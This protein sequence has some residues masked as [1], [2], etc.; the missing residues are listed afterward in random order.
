MKIRFWNYI[1]A[2]ESISVYELKTSPPF[3]EILDRFTIIDENTGNLLDPP[4]YLD[5]PYEFQSIDNEYGSCINFNT[6]KQLPKDALKMISYEETVSKYGDKLILVAS[7]E[8]R[9]KALAPHLPIMYLNQLTPVHFCLLE[10]IGKSRH[11]GQMTVGK[12]NLS[13]VVKDAKLLFYNRT[14]LQKFDLIKVQ[15]STQVVGGRALKSILLRLN[16]FYQPTLCTQPKI[17]KLH[18]IINYLLEAPDYSEQTDVMIKKGL[19]TPPQSKRLQ[20]TINIFNFEEKDII[21][22][23]GENSKMEPSRHTVK[24]KCISLNCQS[25]ESQSDE[26]SNENDSNLKCQ[27]KVGVNLGRQ[28]YECFL[29]AGLKGLTQIDIAQLLGIEF[30][31][32]RTICRVFKARKIVRE[33]LED[34]GRQRTARYIAIAATK[35]IDK[36][37]AKEKSKFLEHCNKRSKDK[38]KSKGDLSSDSESEVPLKKIKKAKENTPVNET[39]QDITE[40]KIMEGCEN[41]TESLLNQKKNPTLR[42]LKFANGIIKVVQDRKYVMGF[43]VLSN[44]VAKETGEPPMDTKALKI[45]TQKLVADGQ[46]KILKIKRPSVNGLT[47]NIFIC[48]PHIKASNPIIRAKYKEICARSEISKKAKLH[49]STPRNIRP[50]THFTYPRYMKIQKLHEFLTQLVYF[51]ESSCKDSING[52]SSLMSI[53]PEM[54]VELALGHISHMDETDINYIKTAAFSL[55]DKVKDAPIRLNRIILQSRSLINSLKVVLKVLALLGLIQLVHQTTVPINRDATDV[56][57]VNRHAKIINT[58]GKWPQPNIDKTVLEKSYHFKKFEDVQEYWSDVHDISINTTINVPRRQQYKL[59]IPVRNEQNLTNY[60]TGEIFGD[61]LGPCG[62]D[63][64]IY[65]D[66]ARLWRS[67]MIKNHTKKKLRKP[68]VKKVKK[69]SSAPAESKTKIKSIKNENNAIKIKDF[70]NIRKR[71]LDSHIKWSNFEDRILMMCKAAVTI[72]SP[73]S[74]PGCLRVRNIVAKDLLSIFDPRKTAAIC[75]KRAIIL[76]TNSTLAHEKDCILNELRCH[77]NLIQK[78]EGLLRVLRLRNYANLSKYVNESRLPLLQLIWI[79]AQIA[80]TK[81]FNRRMPCMAIDLKDFNKKYNISPSSANRAYNLYRTPTSSRPE[82]AILKEAIIMTIMLSLDEPV[83]KKMGKKIFSIFNVYDEP[84]LRSAIQQL[85]KSGA[86]AARD[87]M[88]NSQLKKEHCED[89]VQTMYKIAMMYRR[90]WMSHLEPEFLDSLSELLSSKIPHNGLKGSC[91]INCL[92]CETYSHDVIDIVSDTIPVVTGSAGSILQEEQ[93]NVID[94]ETKF[95]LKS[96]LLGWKNK[97]NVETF[98]ELY[99]NI[100]YDGIFENLIRKSIVDYSKTEEIDEMDNIIQFLEEKES[101]GCTFKELDEKIPDDQNTLVKRLLDLESKE[102]VKRVGLYENVIVL[103]KYAKPY[104]LFVPKNL[105]MIPTPWLTLKAEIQK[106]VFF[107][108]AGVIMNKVFEC[109]GCSVAFISNSIE[110]IT[111]R[112]VQE[113]CMFLEQTKCVE[114]VGVEKKDTDLFTEEDYN[115]VPELY[116]FNPYESPDN[117]LVVP[118]KDCLSKY[119]YIR[120]K[121]LNDIELS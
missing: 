44:L 59:C 68:K 118:V 57:Y 82:F 16:R 89:I 30:Y 88:I 105:Y 52:I 110:Y 61:G 20:K 23:R 7:L 119:A 50:V 115:W 87:K 98:S 19:L 58:M 85:R 46:L 1:L 33:F 34:K 36:Q 42:Q 28:A 67:F 121:I 4:D 18:N 77:R 112:S 90:K 117:I 96:G 108:W 80:E 63:S 10:L 97:S 45:F 38:N 102:I 69:K 24:R 94:I 22:N 100:G 99:H 60:D 43:Q 75:H 101:K 39:K 70:M 66:I 3:I 113:V 62:F 17:G 72:M 76:E 40:V 14:V 21:I 65:M 5:G 8:E 64:S 9:W 29:A 84:M 15:Y 93:L 49:K 51:N 95:K 120:S 107:K 35:Y 11:N 6:R 116:E 71:Q 103:K 41:V 13:K 78:Y 37:Y 54:T 2:S 48:A 111:Y 104:L 47:C 31:T 55:D 114:L 79:I 26:E 74:Q 73:V 83:N 12:T 56:F 81:P 27:Y 86:I 91:D 53:I 32:S 106:D 25:D 109:P 92:L